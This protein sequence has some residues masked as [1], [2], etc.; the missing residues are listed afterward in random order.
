MRVCVT[1]AVVVVIVVGGIDKEVWRGRGFLGAVPCS[2]VVSR[3]PNPLGIASRHWSLD[4][5]RSLP[6]T[7]RQ[8]K[9]VIC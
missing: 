5:R 1:P 6:R 8:L 2:S 7:R 3:G 9:L 4:E